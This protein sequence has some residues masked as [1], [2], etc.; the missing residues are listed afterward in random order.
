MVHATTL[1]SIFVFY[2]GGGYLP[3]Q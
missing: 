3:P 2:G 1:V